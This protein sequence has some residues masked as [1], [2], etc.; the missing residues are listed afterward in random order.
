LGDGIIDFGSI[1][2]AVAA[3]GYQGYVEVEIFNADVWA[4]PPD[5][6]AATVRERFAVVLGGAV[7]RGLTGGSVASQDFG[8]VGAAGDG[9]AVGVEGDGPA[10]CRVVKVRVGWCWL[11]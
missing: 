7:P 8:A 5:E 9:G 11:G 4:A 6:T 3:A 1:S 10:Q 2:D